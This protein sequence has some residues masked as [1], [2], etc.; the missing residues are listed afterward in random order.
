MIHAEQRAMLV[1]ICQNLAQKG[2]LAGTGG[3]IM[4]RVGIDEVLVTPSAKDYHTLESSDICVLSLSDLSIIEG[5]AKPSVESAMHAVILRQ[6]ADIAVS[7]HTHQPLTSACSLLDIDLDLNDHQK[8]LLGSTVVPIH[9]A[10]SGT[11]LLASKVKRAISPDSN[12]YLLK[13]HGVICLGKTFSA[14]IEALDTLE[15]IAL[16]SLRKSLQQQLTC[17]TKNEPHNRE[18]VRNLLAMTRMETEA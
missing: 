17:N 1:S 9:Y 18:L 10:P 3:N 14:A 6:R 15:C 4:V 16:A 2:Y 7:I 12:A 5:N 8:Q 13:N 11:S